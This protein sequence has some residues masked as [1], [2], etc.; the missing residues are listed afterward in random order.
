M[1]QQ[2]VVW[3]D[4][5]RGLHLRYG[6]RKHGYYLFYRTRTGV[7]RRPRIGGHPDMTL[8]QAREVARAILAKVA[9][10][11]DPSDTWRRGRGELTVGELFQREL[12]SGY[13]SDPRFIRSGRSRE[14]YRLWLAAL[15]QFESFKLSEL[16]ARDVRNWHRRLSD[17]PFWANRAL[18][19]LSRLMQIAIEDE[20][21]AVNPCRAVRKHPEPSRDRYATREEVQRL[22]AA[23]RKHA[24][25]FPRETAFVVLLALTGSRPSFLQRA[26]RADLRGNVLV[27]VGKTTA[28]TGVSDAVAIPDSAMRSVVEQLPVREDGLLIGPVR[29]RNYW[30]LICRE[31]GV[32]DLWVRDWRRTFAT[33]GLSSGVSLSLV[34]ELL[35]HRD[36]RSTKVYAKLLPD[37]RV[38]AAEQIA[39]EVQ[40]LLEE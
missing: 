34:G 31:A 14:V 32:T 3:D 4:V 10:G 17:K 36:P 21:I 37:A 13:W 26:K 28:R 18:E 25:A 35:N 12:E 22:A 23:M 30:R 29:Y 24:D 27:G 11:E 38:Q 40:K 20:L 5:V 1:T 8:S 33:F 16:A 15:R 6:A 2:R 19:V 7:Q 39:G 9:A